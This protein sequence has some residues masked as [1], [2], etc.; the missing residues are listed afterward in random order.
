MKARYCYRFYRHSKDNSNFMSAND[1]LGEM[2]KFWG[3]KNQLIQT[4][5]K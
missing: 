2:D 3:E 4:D 1:S 5:L